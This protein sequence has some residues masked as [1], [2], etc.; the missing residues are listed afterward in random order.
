[1][2]IIDTDINLFIGDLD[3][4]TL[5][6]EYSSYYA[7]L[8]PFYKRTLE[9]GKIPDEDS[10]SW[11]INPPPIYASADDEASRE[12]KKADFEKYVSKKESSIKI[13][14]T[15]KAEFFDFL[16]TKSVRYRK[17][18][19]LLGGNINTIITGIASAIAAKL[20]DLAIGIITS[21][22]TTFILVLAKIGKSALCES[23]KTNK[24][25]A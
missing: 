25:G 22:V 10:L 3:A 1:M 18:R 9:E 21:F 6:I 16:C 4:K 17:E 24:D 20:G 2:K 5:G 19:V 7:F 15:L 14:R 13:V 11:I 23:F 8:F 12:M